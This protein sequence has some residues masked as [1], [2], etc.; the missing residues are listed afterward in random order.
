MQPAA[1]RGDPRDRG[2][3]SF[4]IGMGRS[5]E[6]RVR[7]RRFD[8]ASG[9]HDDHAVG[10]PRDHAEVVRDEQDRHPELLLQAVEQLENLRLNRDVQ[11]RR[12]LI[13]NQ[14]LRVADERHRNHH[15][16]PHP[17]RQLMRVVVDALVGVG[18]ADQAQHLDRACARGALGQMLMDDRRLGDLVADRKDGI[19]RRH[20]L[21]EDHRDLIAAD[22]AELGRRQ[23]E[24][25]TSLEL[26]QAAGQDM[27]GRLRNE[28]ENRERRDR[29]AA[30]GFADDA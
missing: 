15:A 10:V 25:I 8:D 13:G 2:Q 4:G 17:P 23:R 18:D 19:Q 9:I 24:Q 30:P 6:E 5:R 16:L 27:P 7:A 22:R 12:R 20:R 14:H 1:R 3:E 21:L 29:L 11:R 26:D 28:P